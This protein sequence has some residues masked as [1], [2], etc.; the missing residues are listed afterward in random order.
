MKSTEPAK[1]PGNSGKLI[2]DDCEFDSDSASP[3]ESNKTQD[4]RK[5]MNRTCKS[6]QEMDLETGKLST[7]EK[8]QS[9]EVNSGEKEEKPE[10]HDVEFLKTLMPFITKIDNRTR[11][12]F[13]KEVTRIAEKFAETT[14]ENEKTVG[15]D[16]GEL[17]LN[18]T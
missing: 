14:Y 10:C 13:R 17:T 2:T 3:D 15:H 11:L 8:V 9:D 7:T 4:S 1:L 5:E 6:D 18:L 12:K 16:D